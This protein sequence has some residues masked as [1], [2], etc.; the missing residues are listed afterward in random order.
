[1]RATLRSVS[2]ALIVSGSRQ[3][4][5]AARP[6]RASGGGLRGSGFR[7]RHVTPHLGR[8]LVLAQT[9]VNNLQQQI[10]VGPGEMIFDFGDQ[11][12]PHPMYTAEH[13]GRAEAAGARRRHVERHF[14][15]RKRLQAAP[16]PLKL[17][18]VDAGA[19]AA[20]INQTS[21]GIVVGEQ[22]RAEVWP[23]AF[24]I[25]PADHEGKPKP[26]QFCG[27]YEPGEVPIGLDNG[28]ILDSLSRMLAD[29]DIDRVVRMIS[30][31]LP[32]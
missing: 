14:V 28:P 30:N 22:Q 16:Q 2:P 31:R 20:G 18:G 27:F 10:V 25:G 23:P 21:V 4:A 5:S 17:G 19:D 3:G 13:Q 9:F 11:F 24:G 15:G 32:R 12:G 8:R 7:I 29:V 6:S 1:V 26:Q